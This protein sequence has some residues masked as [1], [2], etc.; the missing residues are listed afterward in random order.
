MR[1]R[2]R[3]AEEG[4]RSNGE[5]GGPGT[6]A[7]RAKESRREERIWHKAQGLHLYMYSSK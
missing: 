3:G 4:E 2:M 5:G 1:A 7:R 6:C